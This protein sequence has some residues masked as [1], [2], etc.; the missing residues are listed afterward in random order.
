MKNVDAGNFKY[1]VH[2]GKK[3]YQRDDFL[4]AI[5]RPLVRDLRR[6]S[7]RQHTTVRKLKASLRLSLPLMI[8]IRVIDLIIS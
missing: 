5:W 8:V 6:R 4:S 2:N 7:K 1:H 3:P